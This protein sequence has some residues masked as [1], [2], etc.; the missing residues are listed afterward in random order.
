MLVNRINHP[1]RQMHAL[2]SECLFDTIFP[3]GFDGIS[4]ST[5][6][7]Y[8]LTH[9]VLPGIADELEII[10]QVEKQHIFTHVEWE[11]RGVYIE[12]KET[13]GDYAWLTA[14]QIVESAALPTA[15]RQFFETGE[16]ENG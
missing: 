4:V 2:F 14:Q 5:S 13:G 15:F 9:P 10:R 11:M 7:M 16:M 6:A 8:T 12:V 1:T 3:N